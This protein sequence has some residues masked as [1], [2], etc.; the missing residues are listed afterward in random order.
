MSNIIKQDINK[1]KKYNHKNQFE[2]RN[3]RDNIK[4]KNNTSNHGLKHIYNNSNLSFNLIQN[5]FPSFIS[6]FKNEDCQI[7]GNNNIY[8]NLNNQNINN[9]QICNFYNNYNNYY[10]NIIKSNEMIINNIKKNHFLFNLNSNEFGNK[11]N[12]NNY[13]NSLNTD[14]QNTFSN[15]SNLKFD[16][17][18]MNNFNNLFNSSNNNFEIANK[19]ILK[20]IQSKINYFNSIHNIENINNCCSRVSN[21]NIIENNIN[22]INNSLDISKN[23]ISPENKDILDDFMKYINSLPMNLVNFLCTP[24]GTLEI[25]KKLDKSSEEC[26]IFLVNFLNKNGLS[27]IMKN[28]YGNYFFQQLIKKKG[29]SLIPLIISYIEEDFLDISKDF[30]GTFSLQALLDE[31]SSFEEEQRILKY[32]K[33]NELEMA[34][35]KNATHVLQKIVLLFPESH[36][37][38]LN[39]II[40]NH[41]ID[42]SL[43]SNGICLVKIFIK[44]NALINNRKRIKD[45][46]ISNFVRMA[47]SPFGNYGIQYLMEIWNLDDLK[48]IKEKIL[49]NIYKLS[50]QQFSSNVI[51]KAIEIFNEENRIKFIRKLCFDNNF[52]LV[53]LKNKFGKFVLNKAIKYMNFELKNEFEINLINDINNNLYKNKD[54]NKVKKL[55]FKIKCSKLDKEEYFSIIN[56]KENNNLF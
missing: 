40:L 23:A 34:F 4:T 47:E 37:F 14:N 13:R 35:N 17:N 20:N 44:T 19:N 30:S 28:T 3:D 21:Y 29:K 11:V 53:L 43:D 42:L 41:L 56:K 33:N 7:N 15:F 10:P 9:Y 22:N 8:I 39:E 54:K 27:K 12:I 52:I 36:R 51:E 16:M 46:I 31:I 1:G 32:I 45:K 5:N 55:L 48:E 38:Y 24:K 18:Q 25:Q 6:T 50:L 49:E 26:K 2:N